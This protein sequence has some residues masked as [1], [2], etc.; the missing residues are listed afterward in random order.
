MDLFKADHA[1]AA[2]ALL[3]TPVDLASLYDYQI[4]TVETVEA[5]IAAGSRAVLVAM[6][7]G[8]GKTRVA[9]ALLFRLIKH[10]RFRRALFL[11]DRETLGDQATNRFNEVRLENL[12]T[13]AEIYD[14]KELDNIRPDPNICVHLWLHCMVTA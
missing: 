10:G 2:S 5:A 12:Q 9:I 7:T 13:F 11:V 1:A 4:E 6:A 8:T 14:I 3:D